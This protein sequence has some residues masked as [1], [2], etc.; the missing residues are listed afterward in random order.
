MVLT[1]FTWRHDFVGTKS[2]YTFVYKL[3]LRT[4]LC[5]KQEYP[6]EHFG[7]LNNNKTFHRHC[8]NCVDTDC[9]MKS[10]KNFWDN[11][12]CFVNQWTILLYGF[13]WCYSLPDNDG[14]FHIWYGME[15]NVRAMT[16]RSRQKQKKI[17]GCCSSII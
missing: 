17:N 8:I 10:H 11:S 1:I 13:G 7:D 14:P 2:S 9:I 12:F 5:T 3:L 16:L 4:S 6:K 15:I